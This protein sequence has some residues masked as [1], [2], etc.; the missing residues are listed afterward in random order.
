MNS[1]LRPLGCLSVLLLWS[2]FVQS[3]EAITEEYVVHNLSGESQGAVLEAPLGFAFTLTFFPPINGA[4]IARE[5]VA[6]GKAGL[7][8]EFYKKLIPI[9]RALESDALQDFHYE[10]AVR[11]DTGAAADRASHLSMQVAETI[12]WFLTTHFAIGAERLSIIRPVAPSPIS[13]SVADSTTS[14]WRVEVR[15]VER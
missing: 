3:Q 4:S 13:S 12:Q 11:A 10:I 6:K 2:A 9:G 5:Q 15:V 7:D 8:E 1:Y 14:R